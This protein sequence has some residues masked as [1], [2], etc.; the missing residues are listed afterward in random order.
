VAVGPRGITSW[1]REAAAGQDVGR[2]D[3]EAA[4]AAT[5]FF[6]DD[7]LGLDRNRMLLMARETVVERGSVNGALR[8]PAPIPVPLNTCVV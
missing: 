6:D 7:I 8:I 2:E 3:R 1:A 5:A 4:A